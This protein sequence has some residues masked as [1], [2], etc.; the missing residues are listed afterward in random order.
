[1]AEAAAGQTVEGQS[2]ARVA[3]WR[4]DRIGHDPHERV[5][6]GRQH[7][8]VARGRDY[9]DVAP[10]KGVYNGSPASHRGVTVEITRVT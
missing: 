9:D 4:G 7:V 1:M 5:P 6:V 3:W 8:V 10:L 2:H